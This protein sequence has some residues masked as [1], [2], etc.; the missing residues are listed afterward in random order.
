MNT[1]DKK[2]REEVARL[3]RQPDSEI[4]TSDIPEVTDWAGAEVGKF[5]RPMK[6]QVTLRLDADMLEWF[7][8][9]GSKYQTRINQALREYM[10]SHRKCS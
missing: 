2:Q 10:D 7:R 8:G 1:P 4:D 6:K 5:Y 9:Q 3:A